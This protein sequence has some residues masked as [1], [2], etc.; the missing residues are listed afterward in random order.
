MQAF[1]VEDG[2]RTLVRYREYGEKEWR[3]SRVEPYFYVA[4]DEGYSLPPHID[5]RVERDVDVRAY[6]GT[7]LDRV[8]LESTRD[9]RGDGDSPG[10]RDVA[11][12]HYEA[13]IPFERRFYIDE[14]EEGFRD[15]DPNVLHVDIEVDS[16]GAVPDPMDATER[17]V[18]IAAYST[19]WETH[20][21]LLLAPG[22][23]AL[24]SGGHDVRRDDKGRHY[25]EP[26]WAADPGNPENERVFVFR[27]ESDMLSAFANVVRRSSVEVLTGWNFEE[28]DAAYL[29]NRMAAV[30]GCDNSELSQLG[31]SY[32]R[33]WSSKDGRRHIKA[34][35]KGVDVFDMMVAYKRQKRRDSPPSWS[36]ADVARHEGLEVE[37]IGVDSSRIGELWRED[38]AAVMEYN[39]RDA[40]LTHL[41]AERMETFDQFLTFHR[42]LAVPQPDTTKNSVLVEMYVMS[43]APEWDIPNNEIIL[44]S[45]TTNENDFEGGRTEDPVPGA[46]ENVFSVDV[47]SEYPN[48]IR[49]AN[50]S[51]ETV[52]LPGDERFGSPQN[53]RPPEMED[54]QRIE[55]LPHAERLGIL[56]RATDEIMELKEAGTRRRD[57]A[58]PG[59]LEYELA[60]DARTTAKELANSLQG[61]SGMETH[62]LSSN[63]VAA[64]ITALGRET[65]G[66]M[67]RVGEEMGFVFIYGDT[68]SAFF[69][70]PAHRSVEEAVEAMERLCS[71]INDRIAGWAREAFNIADDR[72]EHL[73]VEPDKVAR[74]ALFPPKKKRYTLWLAHKDGKPVDE[75]SH[76]GWETVRSDASE[77]EDALQRKTLEALMHNKSEPFV[78]DRIRSEMRKVADG[79]YEPWQVARAVG[80][81]RAFG[82]YGDN[83]G[84]LDFENVPY[85]V[86][87]MVS[88]NELL[89]ADYRG[90]DKAYMLPVVTDKTVERNGSVNRVNYL[91]IGEDTGLPDWARVNVSKILEGFVK[92]VDTIYESVGWDTA[93]LRDTKSALVQEAQAARTAEQ[94]MTLDGF[95]V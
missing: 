61:V 59:T 18:S 23:G 28:F 68:D 66:F 15:A 87:A 8:V 86:A 84:V 63:E 76:T 70:D 52:V 43:R 51:K 74:R 80:A 42:E 1:Q 72:V 44:D 62:R 78:T 56:P 19:E 27:E 85:F 90:G 71:A 40:Y 14:V 45:K 82:S 69:Y 36:L 60:D 73:E 26:E 31:E 12:N 64:S 65:V 95:T 93:P 57:A 91:A 58:K 81:Q 20:L 79:E 7:R 50:L 29:I 3:T 46:Y 88:S 32:T 53:I 47:T 94:H 2:G 5:G 21:D 30:D 48:W 39:R 25:I 13:D 22:P 9:V 34:V 11:D 41:L 33:A 67:K 6:D 55:F 4:H 24:S 38:P 16:S 89:G 49:A 17:V 77:A 10:A 54:G 37:K 83:P 35:I 75:I 92:K